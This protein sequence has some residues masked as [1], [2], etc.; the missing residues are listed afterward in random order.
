MSIAT[1][2]TGAP[3]STL[4]AALAA[5]RARL[6][7]TEGEAPRVERESTPPPAARGRKA[8]SKAGGSIQPALADAQDDELAQLVERFSLTPF[9]RDVLVMCAGVE[10]DASFASVVA[11]AQA[12][13]A[14][15]GPTFGLALG[16][17]EGAHWSAL[18]PTAALRRWRL[19]HLQ[20]RAGLTTGLLRIDERVLHYL[21]GVLY[22]EPRLQGLIEPV[23]NVAELSPS[24]TV[25]GRTMLAVWT[26]G[27]TPLARRALIAL[28]G[29]DVVAHEAVAATAAGT[30]GLRLH[31]L[32]ASAIP[33]TGEERIALARLWEREAMLLGSAL[34]VVLEPDATEDNRERVR[35]LACEISGLLVL[36]STERLELRGRDVVHIEVQPPAPADQALVWRRELGPRA[37]ELNGAVER[38]AAQF[39]LDGTS[40]RRAARE[41]LAQEKGDLAGN[42]WRACR[43]QLRVGMESLAQRIEP[44]ATWDDLVLP[45]PQTLLLRTIVAQ[46]RQRSRVADEWGFARKSERGLGVHALFAGPSGTGKTMAA[47]VMASELALDLYRIDLSAVVSKYV[48]E[49]E[50]NLRRV[51]DAAE[52]AGAI[53]LF[54]EADALFG[55][56]SEVRDSHDRYANIEVSFLLQRCES[57]RGL[58][59]LTTNLKTAIDPAFARRL[60]F[61]VHFP[62]PDEVRR[63]EI[64]RRVFP[65]ET[66]RGKLD[67]EKLAALSLT[68][69]HIRNVALNAAFLA[70][71]EGEPVRMRHLAAAA[72]AEHAKLERPLSD[73]EVDGWT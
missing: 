28:A 54:D 26:T 38:I 42:L 51:F 49:T 7:G 37:G 12:G 19:L 15:Q 43:R 6:E 62:F 36:S 45:E 63:L 35:S 32:S 2:I 64:W 56:R 50:K 46:V 24:Q 16:A 25:A 58:A 44:R 67:Y 9:E 47:E 3:P 61:T 14:V 29:R 1:T 69:G 57:Y 60:R 41:T 13:R 33:A 30:L 8:R 68:G 18:A 48:G 53:L 4:L 31:R 40:I 66:P 55:R 73:A 21:G 70:A 52:R 39:Q 59:I 5:V 34:L 71:D 23:T 10:L 27:E 72:R 22:F 11:R 17:L 20:P 65:A